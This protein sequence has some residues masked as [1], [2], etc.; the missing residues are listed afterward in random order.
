[1]QI[2]RILSIFLAAALCLGLLALASVTASAATGDDGT[3]NWDFI[4]P[5]THQST[6]PAGYVGIYTP[7]DL[8]DIRNHPGGQYILMNNIDLSGWDSASVR[9]SFS[10]TACATRNSSKR[11]WMA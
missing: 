1:M 8:D 3:T 9:R 10:T 4:V 6:V 7:E 2:K 5:V 11:R